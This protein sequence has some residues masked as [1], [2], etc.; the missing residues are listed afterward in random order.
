LKHSNKQEVYYC[1]PYVY[2]DRTKMKS[3]IFTQCVGTVILI[4][5]EWYHNFWFK[6]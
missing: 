6:Y 3:N 4:C 5:N 1:R 2:I